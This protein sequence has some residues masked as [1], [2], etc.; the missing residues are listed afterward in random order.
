ML[1]S[2]PAHA[3]VPSGPLPQLFVSLT[4][5]KS[6]ISPGFSASLPVTVQEFV[7]IDPEDEAK[8]SHVLPPGY[9]IDYSGGAGRLF[10]KG[11]AV[12]CQV[13]TL[14]FPEMQAPMIQTLLRSADPRLSRDPSFLK[15]TGVL[16]LAIV[17]L[18][19][20]DLSSIFPVPYGAKPPELSSQMMVL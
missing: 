19:G 9:R 5:R 3:Q 4:I 16:G 11:G 1:L 6:A 20:R 8:V 18:K 17:G 10:P 2:T 12:P 13:F 7:P 14:I 15:A